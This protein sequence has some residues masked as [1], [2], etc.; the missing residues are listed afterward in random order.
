MVLINLLIE[1]EVEATSI[2]EVVKV[3][4]D[5]MDHLNSLPSISF[6]KHNL[7]PMELS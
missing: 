6:S 3:V 1:E 5:L 7:I 4:K 2:I